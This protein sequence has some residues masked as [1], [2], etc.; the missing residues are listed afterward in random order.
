MPP[1]PTTRGCP[2]AEPEPSTARGDATPPAKDLIARALNRV[3]EVMEH[4]MGNARREEHRPV[5]ERDQ[6]WRGF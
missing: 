1:R 4:V 6:P 2:V 5:N 3:A